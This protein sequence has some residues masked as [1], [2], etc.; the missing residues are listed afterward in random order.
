MAAIFDLPL[1][2]KSES[3]HTKTAVLL[4]PGNMGAANGIP[5]L[6]CVEAEI[7][8]SFISTSGYWRSSLMC[9]S[10]RHL[11]VFC[12]HQFCCV[13]WPR[14]CGLVIGISLPSCVWA[15]TDVFHSFFRFMAAIS[16]SGSM[17]SHQLYIVEVQFGR[18]TAPW[19][20]Y[21]KSLPVPKIIW[22]AWGLR[23]PPPFG[24]NVT[25]NAP[26]AQG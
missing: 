6:I 5:L 22:G 21:K 4:N 11:T 16:I 26:A 12:L 10:R 17:Y 7:L 19:K 25:K 20:L 15:K 2:R 13:P 3:V 23:K 14:K 1:T 18:P 9:D 8:R 24:T